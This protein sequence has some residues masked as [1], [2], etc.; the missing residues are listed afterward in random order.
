[1]THVVS[2]RSIYIE[3]AT[4]QDQEVKVVLFTNLNHNPMI[5]RIDVAGGGDVERK[6]L[7]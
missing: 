5:M 2:L 7:G 4:L 6:L 1:M 3:F